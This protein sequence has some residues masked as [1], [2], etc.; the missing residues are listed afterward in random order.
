MRKAVA[1]A[2]CQSGTTLRPVALGIHDGAVAGHGPIGA[3][4]T[5]RDALLTGATAP[6]AGSLTPNEDSTER[7]PT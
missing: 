6:I 2:G 7:I 1:T 5:G 3:L 4:I